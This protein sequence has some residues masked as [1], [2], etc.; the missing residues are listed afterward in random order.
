MTG[1]AAEE[2]QM[3]KNTHTNTRVPKKPNK[4]LQVALVIKSNVASFTLSAQTFMR[5]QYV[6]VRYQSPVF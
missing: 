1:V 2:P 5:Y 3:Y 4:I 6:S